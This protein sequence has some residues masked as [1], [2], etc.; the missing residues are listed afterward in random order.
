LL[1]RIV[2]VPETLV[3][4]WKP[5]FSSGNVCFLHAAA[6]PTRASSWKP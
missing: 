3:L 1:K 2:L 5:L 6:F 4:Y